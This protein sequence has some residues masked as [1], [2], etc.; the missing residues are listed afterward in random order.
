MASRQAGSVFRLGRIGNAGHG[1]VEAEQ[2]GGVGANTALPDAATSAA[3]LP[4]GGSVAAY[5]RVML[6]RGFDTVEHSVRMIGQ[7]VRAR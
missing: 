1:G 3:E 5:E 2:A 6:P 4:G 7:M